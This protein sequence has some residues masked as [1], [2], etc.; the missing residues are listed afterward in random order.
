[1]AHRETSLA[2]VDVTVTVGLAPM[3]SDAQE[4]DEE[5]VAMNALIGTGGMLQPGQPTILSPPKNPTTHRPPPPQFF[6]LPGNPLATNWFDEAD[7][8]D[9]DHEEGDEATHMLG[10]TSLL[11]G[12]DL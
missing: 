11:S 10:R 1:M 5:E 9:D 8:K 2:A 7:E 4:D 3:E 6:T 12:D